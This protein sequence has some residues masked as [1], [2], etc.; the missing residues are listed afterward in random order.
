MTAACVMAGAVARRLL[1]TI[2]VEVAAHTVEIGGIT[3]GSA[4]FGAVK[5]AAGDPLRCADTAAAA[6]MTDLIAQARKDGDSL[7]GIVEGMAVNLPV[8]LGE[9]YFDTLDGELAKALFSI[10]A[11]KGVEFGAGFNVADMKGSENNDA[12]V[13]RDGKVATATNHA[14]GVL[15]GLSSG[16]P[17][18]V[19]VAV[20]PTPSISKEQPTVNLTTL[21]ETTITVGGRH[22]ACIVPRAIAVVEAMMA[23]TLADFALRAGAVPRIIA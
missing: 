16:M 18:I 5:Q 20:K 7:G 12:F 2:G 13:I 15:G 14:G 3:A 6:K 22:D 9:P 10:P 11:V 1:G 4:D 19:R 17:L 23:I 21:E 8:G